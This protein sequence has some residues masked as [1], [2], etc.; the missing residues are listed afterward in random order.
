VAVIGEPVTETGEGI[1]QVGGLTAPD[2][3]PVTAQLVVTCP[4]KPPLGEMVMVELPLPPG[5][6]MV[7]PE[8][9]R[10]KFCAPTDTSAEV[11]A[12]GSPPRGYVAV[13]V[14]EY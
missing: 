14:T 10:K 8:L 3:P 7:A 13:M 9:L 11:E 4:V 1:A 5:D 6:A 12:G 2:G